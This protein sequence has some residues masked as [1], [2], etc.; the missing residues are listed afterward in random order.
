MPISIGLPIV[1][2]CSVES[3]GYNNHAGCHAGAISIGGDHAEC[4]TFVDT[5][6][7]GGREEKAAVGACTRSDCRFNDNLICAA[8]S[9]TIGASGDI[10]DCLTFE[11]KEDATASA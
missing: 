3:C 4:H 7:K 2:S 9:V 1:S 11:A 6:N 8:E 10:A 5:A